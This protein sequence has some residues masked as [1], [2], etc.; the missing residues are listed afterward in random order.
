MQPQIG[1]VKLNCEGAWKG[2][3]TPAGCGGFLRD[4]DGRWIKG[5]FKKIEVSDAFHAEMSDMYLGLDLAWRENT[6]HLIVGSYSKILVNMIIENCN[7][8]GTTPTL[9]KRIQQLLSLSWT[10]K[11][12]HT[13]CEGNKNADWLANFSIL[14]DFLDFHILENFPGELQNLLF[15]GISGTCMPKNVC[16][17]S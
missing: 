17:I 4:S 9:V 10:V 11:I 12:T 6:T 7:F 15:N 8:G 3:S 13:W 1:W 5:Y 14:T 2:S 16:L